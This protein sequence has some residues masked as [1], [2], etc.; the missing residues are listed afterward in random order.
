MSFYTSL[1]GLNGAQADISTISNNVANVGTTGFKRSRAEFGDIFATSPLQNASS[2]V[3]SGT[4]L[5]SIKQQFTQ[6]NIQSSLNALDLAISGQGFFAM[7]PSL[8]SSQTVYT[9]NGS[10]SVNNDRYVVDDKGQY[11]QVFPVNDDGS[12]TST[13]A[14]SATNLQL[15]VKSGLPNATTLIQ[16][17]LN[18]PAD[19]AIIPQDPKY[20]ASNPYVF[21]HND[22]TTFN[23]STSITIYDSL[24][25]PTI[26][27]IYYVKTSNSTD[28]DPTNKWMT[29]VF[30][31]DKELNPSL[32]TA[33]DAQSATLYVNKFGQTTTDP[34]QFDPSFVANQP[35]PLY[36]QDDQVKKVS[37]T[38]AKVVG[39][40]Q[41]TKGF[42]FGDTDAN[43]VTIVT[44]PASYSSTH[45]A[46]AA[47]N[48][49]TY[50]G[51]DMFTVSVDGSTPQS[52]SIGAGS[53][54]GDE[55]AAEMTRAVNAKFSDAKSFRISDTYRDASGAVNPGNDVFNINLSSTTAE[56]TSIALS[57]PL[58][59]DLLGTAGATGTPAAVTTTGV[60]SQQ[61][62]Y[63]D[64]TRDDLISLAQAKVN[65]QL[66][67][68]HN[69]FGKPANWVDTN[70][71]PIVVGFDV[72]SRS[73]TFKV[74]PAQLGSD[75]QLPE[76]RYQNIQVYNPTNAL[77]DLGIPTQTS[78]SPAPIGTN[79]EWMGQAVLPSGPPITAA[80]DQRTGIT[81]SYNKDTRQFE[82]SSGT[83]GESSKITVGR[84]TLA[85][86]TDDALTQI[87]SY[88]LSHLDMT[89]AQSVTL[90]SD[91][92]SFTYSYDPATAGSAVLPTGATGVEGFISNLKQALP[93]SFSSTVENKVGSSGQSEVQT[94]TP[95]GNLL[96]GDQFTVNLQLTPTS[97][98]TNTIAS[99]PVSQITLPAFDK[100]AVPAPTPAF[101][102][103]KLADAIQSAIDSQNGVVGSAD[104]SK[105]VLV[106]VSGSSLTFTYQ[107]GFVAHQV[108]IIQNVRGT[109][110][111]NQTPIPLTD[112]TVIATPTTV[113][114][115][116]SSKTPEVQIATLE[117][118]I[119]TNT[120]QIN[121]GDIYTVSVPKSDG[122]VVTEDITVGAIAVG[123]NGLAELAAA[124]QAEAGGLGTGDLK[125][126]AA[127]V[128]ADAAT[129]TL[130]FT[131]A[132]NA[133]VVG[134]FSIKQAKTT[135]QGGAT[136]V[137]VRP[138]SIG[139]LSIASDGSGHLLVEGSPTGEPFRLNLQMNGQVLPAEPQGA[140]LTQPGRQIGQSMAAS[141]TSPLM[142]QGNNDLLGIGVSKTESIVSGTGLSSTAAVAYGGT[143][144]TP[145]N[146]T[147]VLNEGL[148]ENKMTFTIDG[149]TGS[150]TLPIR[151]YTGDTLASAIQQRINQI[152]DP[153]TGRVVS[154]ATVSFDPTNNRLKFTSGTTGSSSQFN[155]VGPAN[156]GL[157]AVTQNP[158]TVPQITPLTQAVDENKNPLYVDANGN[159]TT[160]KPST[161]SQTWAPL[162]LTPGELKFDTS[163]KLSSP[164]QG[165]V[166]SPFNPGNGANP[167]NVTIDYGKYS[168]QYT[169]PFSVLS[170]QQDGYT[171]GQ[172]D[173]LNI[174]ANG[175]VRANY[176]N[177]QTKALG[178]IIL[179]NFANPNGLKQVGNSNYVANSVSGDAVLGQAGADGFGSIQ[180][181]ALER[182]N[183]DI[184]E[185]LVDLITAQRNF[186]AN[187]KAIETETTL[188]QTII[189]IRG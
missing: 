161:K 7:K 92:R 103:Q 123:S 124:I 115:A 104:S 178:K 146:Q 64:L 184:T 38:P 72:S 80:N 59:I 35:S 40:I 41:N 32:I 117:P 134:K 99:T 55:L 19:A 82:F 118:E 49:S 73:L 114:K 10:F 110:N 127:S 116:G 29:H 155:V 50:W 152:Q 15:P 122:T 169:Q 147:F 108:S 69:D 160:V 78:S 105:P 66:N 20:T 106:Q 75:A 170:L 52:I 14:A 74:D 179:A 90:E 144:I 167:L 77:N 142:Y 165:V 30:V 8:T 168:T 119:N 162:Y 46:N 95:W 135:P 21:N 12:V 79:S 3:G 91:G 177:G 132:N 180:S 63:Q 17:G 157:N 133:A 129:N 18:L 131:F 33:K 57:P 4:I 175:T 121:A 39:E 45:E 58:E 11:L 156:F 71:P 62:N 172:L 139:P 27:T 94:I 67:A 187:S 9:R 70:N 22:P 120:L 42:D 44:D 140:S 5:K 109:D 151:A 53:Y 43:K 128:T 28:T 143:A 126:T 81:V 183:V 141:A 101:R 16:L 97:T 34:T 47:V 88:D 159:I 23:K 166:Y 36:Y 171:S 96:S 25:N 31:G 174:D 84:T 112:R 76:N 13:G 164:T 86:T 154:G 149:I 176:T 65:E 125:K 153:V 26:S 61:L 137:T 37:S 85:Q 87:N 145:M 107:P 113:F 136:P 51:K 148:G 189:Q 102:L 48:T 83:T 186:Q 181:G 163:G 158:G 98:S 54:T 185:E 93:V 150:I 89:K 111:S 138:D 188:T 100:N 60:K 56:G 68:R 1:T 182:S 6:G 2:A 173:G 130:S 24:G